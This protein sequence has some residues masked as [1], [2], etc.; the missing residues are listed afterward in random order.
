MLLL[1]IFPLLEQSGPRPFVG[2]GTTTIF[3]A[4]LSVRDHTIIFPPC[5]DVL[6]SEKN[7]SNRPT[8]ASTTSLTLPARGPENA[9][10]GDRLR[11]AGTAGHRARLLE[12]QAMREGDPDTG[13]DRGLVKHVGR[14]PQQQT[15]TSHAPHLQDEDRA[16][17]GREVSKNTAVQ[18][19][20]SAPLPSALALL[21]LRYGVAGGS[22][23]E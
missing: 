20:R 16:A 10:F 5:D 23:G 18:S 9:G 12:G 2:R 22:A 6:V 13:R 21:T 19:R 11:L 17:G 3:S 7:R 15:L 14:E 1:H 4:G 8:R